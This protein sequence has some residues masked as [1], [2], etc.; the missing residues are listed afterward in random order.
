V[1][2]WVDRRETQDAYLA[3]TGKVRQ[4]A[5]RDANS[6]LRDANE[7]LEA[8]RCG[9]ADLTGPDAR[10]YMPGLRA[11]VTFGRAVTNVLQNLRGVVGKQD[12]DEWYLPLQDEMQQDALLRF[13]YLLRTEVLKKGTLQV[14]MSGKFDWAEYGDMQSLMQNPPAGARSFFIEGGQRGG[15]RVE[16][17]DGTIG[18]YYVDLPDHVRRTVTEGFHFADPPLTHLGKPLQDTSVAALARVYVAYLENLLAQATARF[19]Q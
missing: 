13:F 17:P 10:R 15:W 18:T 16:L 19:G 1:T 14:S 2:W 8:A 3:A 12:F 6:V 4:L 9:L 7:T 11:V 5:E